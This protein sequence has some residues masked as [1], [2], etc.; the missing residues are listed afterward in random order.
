MEEIGYRIDIFT[1]DGIAGCQ[2]DYTHWLLGVSTGNKVESESILNADVLPLRSPLA[3][4]LE[5]LDRHSSLAP[6]TAWRL[7]ARCQRMR[8]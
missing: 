8:R 1:F 5:A 6:E 2:R 7:R 4:Q 3:Q